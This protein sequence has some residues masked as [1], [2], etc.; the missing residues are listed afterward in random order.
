MIIFTCVLKSEFK[1]RT[2]YLLCKKRSIVENIET[3]SFLLSKSN[4]FMKASKKSIFKT[5]M[6]SN[7]RSIKK[8]ILAYKCL[9]I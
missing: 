8:E 4:T 1:K 3:I 2:L 7:Y 6:S 5:S 9:L